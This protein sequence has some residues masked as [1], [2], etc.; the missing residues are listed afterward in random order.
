[1]IRFTIQGIH[2]WKIKATHIYLSTSPITSPNPAPGQFNYKQEFK[3]AVTSHIAELPFPSG[4]DCKND[5]QGTVYIAVH[6]DMVRFGQQETGWAFGPYP[7]EKKWGWSFEYDVCCTCDSSS[8]SLR[9]ET[10]YSFG[11]DCAN[12][13]QMNSGGCTLNQHWKDCFPTGITIGCGDNKL[14]FTSSSAVNQFLPTHA[15]YSFRPFTGSYTNPADARNYGDYLAGQLLTLAANL[16]LDKCIP[17]WGSCCEEL[18]GIHLCSTS[19]KRNPPDVFPDCSPFHGKTVC[20][21][22]EYANNV[23]GG[24]IEDNADI[25]TGCVVRI[26]EAFMG[27]GK[28]LSEVEGFSSTPCN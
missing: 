9:T 16:G 2:M 10:E 11:T 8:C 21:F 19:S 4:I 13:N 7:F 20:E 3:T 15:E 25:V 12:A 18:C 27:N 6:T 1:M 17:Q 28:R 14:T 24:C 22:F 5:L 23:L 26:N